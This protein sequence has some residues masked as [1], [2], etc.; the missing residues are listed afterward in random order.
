VFNLPGKTLVALT[1]GKETIWLTTE[2]SNNAEKLKYY[3]KPYEGFRGIKQSSIINLTDSSNTPM[4]NLSL[5]KN[6]LNFEGVTFC[7]LNERKLSDF[8]LKHFPCTDMIILS[9]KSLADPVLIRKC[10]PEAVIIENRTFV[11]VGEANGQLKTAINDDNILNTNS[12]GAVQIKVKSATEKGRS[13]F[14]CR[15]FNQD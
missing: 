11:K 6:F 1:T 8:D 2:K 5:K 7:V 15:Y 10:L 4:N 12:G 9:E 3:I 14:S 13:I